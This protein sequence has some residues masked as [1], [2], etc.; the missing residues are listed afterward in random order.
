MTTTQTTQEPL[1]N[2]AKIMKKLNVKDSIYHSDIIRRLSKLDSFTRLAWKGRISILFYSEEKDML[3]HY[4][5]GDLR[6]Y[7]DPSQELIQEKIT[8]YPKA[9]VARESMDPRFQ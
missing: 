7:E 3:L 1:R 2:R 4:L 6:L 9:E 8:Q 5:E